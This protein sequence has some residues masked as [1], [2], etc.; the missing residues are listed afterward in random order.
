MSGYVEDAK[1][2]EYAIGAWITGVL[3][4]LASWAY[5]VASWGFLLGVGL[6]WIPA[7][8]IGAIAGLLWPLIALAVGG[9]ILLLILNAVSR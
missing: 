3:A 8:F 4:F 7:L 2:S 5:A 9:I 6:G 1:M